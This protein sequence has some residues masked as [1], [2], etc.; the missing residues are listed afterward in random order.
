MTEN[1]WLES[2]P[3]LPTAGLQSLFGE[4]NIRKSTARLETGRTIRRRVD[5]RRMV[6]LVE[7]RSAAQA[8]DALPEPNESI[9]AVMSGSYDGFAVVP[10]VLAL[11]A[12]VTIT[13]LTIATLG[14]NRANADELFA[15]LDAGQVGRCTLVASNYFRSV[16]TE[17]F[18]Y[19]HAGLTSRGQR[20]AILRS[21]AKLL[22]FEMTDGRAFVWE[23]SAN[24][25][26][27]RNAETFVLSQSSELLAFH[28]GW[29]GELITKAEN[30][31]TK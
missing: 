29:I 9:H 23:S 15:M 31:H 17:L 28:R 27:C 20:C 14:F 25:R 3:E 2:L 24:L 19:I 18:G 8:I 11:A 12:P 7:I 1:N 16:D 22:L 21:H 13:A 4:S 10:A 6:R 26:S 5:R 30:A